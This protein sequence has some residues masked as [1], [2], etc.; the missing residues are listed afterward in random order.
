MICRPYLVITTNKSHFLLQFREY[1]LRQ[2]H[3]MARFIYHEPTEEE[4]QF[5]NEVGQG[6]VFAPGKLT[7]IPCTVPSTESWEEE[8]MEIPEV[9]RNTTVTTTATEPQSGAQ[10]PQSNPPIVSL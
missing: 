5:W 1:Y 2:N 3:A 7:D 9:G 6:L 8:L 4:H 10:T